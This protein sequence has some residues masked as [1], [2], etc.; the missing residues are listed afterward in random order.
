MYYIVYI[1]LLWF[2]LF[3][4]M[5]T[6][7]K[8]E[9]FLDLLKTYTVNKEVLQCTENQLPFVLN[10]LEEIKRGGGVWCAGRAPS[11]RPLA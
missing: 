3:Y 4:M 1:S 9:N 10:L 8:K 5:D 6:L 2:Q 7:F 11:P